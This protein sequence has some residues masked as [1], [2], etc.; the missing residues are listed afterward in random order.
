MSITFKKKKATGDRIY[1]KMM[2]IPFHVT[3]VMRED[4]HLQTREEDYAAT[5]CL[6]QNFSLLA[7]EKQLGLVWETYYFIFEPE[8]RAALGV[9][10]GEKIVGQLH[11]GYFDED[12]IPKIKK[13]QRVEQRLTVF[14]TAPQ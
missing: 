11:V 8:F 9:Q 3:V 4:A 13:R 2:N 14:N 12:Q 6:I 1:K 5:S 10:L 7:W